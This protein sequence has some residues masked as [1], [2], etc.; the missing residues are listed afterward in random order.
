MDE[1]TK[2]N[3]PDAPEVEQTSSYSEMLDQFKRLRQDRAAAAAKYDKEIEDARRRDRLMKAVGG[4]S[5]GLA[6]YLTADAVEDSGIYVAPQFRA[7]ELA[8]KLATDT[9]AAVEARKTGLSRKDME[10]ADLMKQYSL[11]REREKRRQSDLFRQNQLGQG[12]ANLQRQQR[13]QEIGEEQFDTT[14]QF[15]KERATES[16]RQFGLQQDLKKYQIDKNIPTFRQEVIDPDTGKVVS[17][18]FNSRTGEEIRDLGET[19]QKQASALKG[20]VRQVIDPETKKPIEKLFNPVTGEEIRTLGEVPA[21][22]RTRADR[23]QFATI[24]NPETGE[25]MYVGLDPMTGEIVREVGKRG[26]REKYFKDPSSG[27]YITEDELMEKKQKSRGMQEEPV[28]KTYDD[29]L[30]VNPNKAKYL[31]KQT[32]KF[33]KESKELEDFEN[34]LSNIDTLVSE[35]IDGTMGAIKRQFGRTIGGEK[36]VMTDR[37]VDAFGGTDKAIEAIAQYAHAKVH[38]GMTDQI[39]NNYMRLLSAAKKSAERRRFNTQSRYME[40]VSNRLGNVDKSMISTNMGFRETPIGYVEVLSGS[41]KGQQ[42]P[43]IN[44]SSIDKLKEL[45]K[46]GKIKLDLF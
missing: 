34:S 20:I 41:S 33:S 19:P 35:N 46:Q 2:V 1:K 17:K 6:N 38:G 28:I 14:Q 43:I 32:E 26:F 9:Q 45:E 15:K 23:L 36:G 16:D 21:S 24:E 39:R 7:A 5:S 3:I 27:N 42:R 25:P 44:N 22:A 13:G 31:D 18:L 10:L 30:Q 4:I 8:D 40:Q 37:D 29:L 12:I 11:R